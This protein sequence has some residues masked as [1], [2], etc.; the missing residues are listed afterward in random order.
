MASD[1]MLLTFNSE[2]KHSVRYDRVGAL[3]S[4]YI[5]KDSVVFE[6]GSY[7]KEILVILSTEEE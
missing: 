7:P 6:N 4:V 3:R 2:K 5:M 1:K